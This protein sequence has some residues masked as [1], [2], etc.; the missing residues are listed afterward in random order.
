MEQVNQALASQP[1][2]DKQ[3]TNNEIR[4]TPATDMLIDN[5]H[6]HLRANHFLLF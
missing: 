6:P 2:K 5:T 3:E 1:L 4:W